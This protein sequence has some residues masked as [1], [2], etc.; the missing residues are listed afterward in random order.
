MGCKW[1]TNFLHAGLEM[2]GMLFYVI[3]RELVSIFVFCFGTFSVQR[4]HYGVHKV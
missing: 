3:I 2:I 4:F 1:A